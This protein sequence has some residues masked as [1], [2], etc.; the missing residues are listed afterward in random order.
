MWNFEAINFE[1]RGDIFHFWRLLIY[2]ALSDENSQ[3][4]GFHMTCHFFRFQGIANIP[5]CGFHTLLLIYSALSD[6][7]SLSI[8]FYKTC[9]FFQISRNWKYSVLTHTKCWSILSI[10]FFWNESCRQN[11]ERKHDVM[12]ER[13][14]DVRSSLINRIR[15]YIH[16]RVCV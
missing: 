8:G 2:P 13:S 16:E 12:N 15:Y 11:I 4:I 9:H 10:F 1:I 14:D 5:S 7:N 3:S 6:E